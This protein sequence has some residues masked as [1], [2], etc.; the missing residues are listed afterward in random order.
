MQTA[1]ALQFAC[2]CPISGC[3]IEVLGTFVRVGFGGLFELQSD[4]P[5]RLR[6]ETE[7]GRAGV[8]LVPQTR[9]FGEQAIVFAFQ[10][11]QLSPLGS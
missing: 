5:W 8:Q 3:L 6:A 9:V 1:G 11:P 2:H 7:I 10:S 4:F